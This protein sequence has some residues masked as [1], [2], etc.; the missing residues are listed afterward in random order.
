M[1]TVTIRLAGDN[2]VPISFGH[3][4]VQAGR[5]ASRAQDQADRSETQAD[6]AEDSASFAEEFSGPAYASQAAGE[7]ATTEGQFFRVPLGTTPETY[8]RYQRTSGSSIVAASL[9]TTAAL[10]SGDADKGAALLATKLNAEGAAARLQAEKNADFVNLL[11]FITED[12]TTDHTVAFEKACAASRVVHLP[13]GAFVCKDFQV[14]RGQVFIGKGG[15]VFNS[16]DPKTKVSNPDVGGACF[17]YTEDT[18]TAGVKGP[19]FYDMEIKADYPIRLNDENTAIIG[20]SGATVNCPPIQR[21]IIN[22]CVLL[23]RVQGTGIGLSMTRCFDGMVTNTFISGFNINILLWSCDLN[24]VWNNRSLL[25]KSYHILDVGTHTHGS[26]N[27]IFHNDVLDMTSTDGIYIKSSGRHSRVMYN[28]L[29]HVPGR[30]GSSATVKG[31][32]DH[33]TVDQPIFNGQGPSGAHS[34]VSHYNRIDGH[35]YATEY[36]YRLQSTGRT[37]A[38]IIDVGTTGAT[39][40]SPG[41]LIVDGDGNNIDSFPLRVNDANPTKWTLRGAIFG[42]WDGFESTVQKS[43]T[44]SGSNL[45]QFGTRLNTNGARAFLM[46]KHDGFLFKKGFTSS[47]E[48]N[49]PDWLEPSTE[50]VAEILAKTVVGSDTLRVGHQTGSGGSALVNYVLTTTESRIFYTFTAPASGNMGLYFRRLNDDP[51]ESD[52]KIRSIKFTRTA[53]LGNYGIV[54]PRQAAISNA[55]DAASAIT[56]VNA[57]LAALRAHKLIET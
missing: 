10:A 1:P 23:P 39:A 34:V 54:G 29:E 11:D 49:M 50:Y 26:E 43:L 17:L 21:A 40:S 48:M 13:D 51:G 33:S 28:Y 8:T 2:V 56:R 7:A 24:T 27:L 47:F 6:R 31:F 32:L 53:D 19:E 44:V 57:V 18:S 41:I 14:P 55:T 9:A 16:S 36:R 45:G 35:T 46:Q 25:A 22:G 38:D 3:D 5:Q 42:D 20:D 37:Y 12:M 30:D 52:I 15:S 4:V